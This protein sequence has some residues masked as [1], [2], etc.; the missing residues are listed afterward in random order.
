MNLIRFNQ[1]PVFNGM[2]SELFEDF[3]KN[4]IFRNNEFK[5]VVPSVNIRENEDNFL[6][7]LAAPGM[8]KEDFNIR[9]NNN[10]LTISAENKV[11][12]EEKT[13][14][15][16]RREFAYGTF[17]RSFTLPKSI[18]LDKIKAD[19]DKGIL[20]LSLPKREESKAVIDREIA[21]S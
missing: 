4:F 14:K 19:Y 7:E 18:D 17:S 3:D 9:L 10:V 21:I 12:N 5:G 20:A 15:F 6:L 13:E 2:L 8:K 11:E 1:H 16:T